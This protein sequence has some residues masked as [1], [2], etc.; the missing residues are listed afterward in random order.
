MIRRNQT[1]LL[2]IAGCLTFLVLPVLFSPFPFTF[3]N[4]LHNP[5]EQ[6]D[7][8]SHILMIVFFYVNYYFFLP[9]VVDKPG[10]LTYTFLLVLSLGLITALPNLII[11][12]PEMNPMPDKV[13]LQ[14]SPGMMHNEPHHDMDFHRKEHV[15]IFHHIGHN[16]W[17]FLIIV[18]FSFSLFLMIRLREV[19]RVRL[20]A[21]LTQLK[22]QIHPHYLFNTLNSIYGSALEEKASRTAAAL[23]RLSGV[24]RYVLSDNKEEFVPLEREITFLRDYIELQKLRLGETVSVTFEVDGNPGGLQIAPLTLITFVE[25]AFRHGV[26]PEE[27][28][29]VSFVISITADS[30]DFRSSNT[31]M[32][33]WKNNNYIGSLSIENIRKQLEQYYPQRY[34]L[35]INDTGNTFSVVLNLRLK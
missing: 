33:L 30:L 25:N 13:L 16:L 35:Q 4:F 7:I 2:H 19:K 14:P 6:R 24:L 21:E 20:N 10:I 29:N 31:K 3:D 18:F 12:Q 15:S 11:P 32:T 26:N 17:L 23:M 9:Q 1:I 34:L 28:S 27:T 8:L 22:A 5:F